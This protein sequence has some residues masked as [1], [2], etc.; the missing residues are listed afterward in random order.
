M[1]FLRVDL[2]HHSSPTLL[3]VALKEVSYGVNLLAGGLF[4]VKYADDI[5]LLSNDTE[6]IQTI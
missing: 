6:A 5:V 2:S 1:W 4:S 3:S